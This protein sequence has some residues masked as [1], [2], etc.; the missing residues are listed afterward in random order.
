MMM[1]TLEGMP[2]PGAIIID[3]I[4]QPIAAFQEMRLGNKHRRQRG[5]TGPAEKK[6]PG[7]IF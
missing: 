6:Q 2:H 7:C 4:E 3:S 5:N 1:L